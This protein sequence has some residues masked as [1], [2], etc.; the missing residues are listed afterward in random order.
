MSTK[1]KSSFFVEGD[2]LYDDGTVKSK[3]YAPKSFDDET[4]EDAEDAYYEKYFA[5]QQQSPHGLGTYVLAYSSAVG[6]HMYGHIISHR[7]DSSI[8][9]FVYTIQPTLRIFQPFFATHSQISVK[10]PA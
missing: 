8:K 6:S 4:W 1:S 9:N 5:A 2:E 10:K 3:Y 7:Y